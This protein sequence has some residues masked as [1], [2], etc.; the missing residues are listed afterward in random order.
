MCVRVCVHVC[1]RV[2]ACVCVLSASTKYSQSFVAQNIIWIL[3]QGVVTY[4]SPV[5]AFATAIKN[6]DLWKLSLPLTAWLLRSKALDRLIL[7]EF[8]G[9]N[10]ATPAKY[11]RK[12]V[13]RLILV[14][15]NSSWSLDR[16]LKRTLITWFHF[17]PGRKRF[18]WRRLC[19]YPL[20]LSSFTISL[21]P[22]LPIWRRA[23]LISIANLCFPLKVRIAAWSVQNR[24]WHG[25]TPLACHLHH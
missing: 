9:Q 17:D 14:A 20:W 2:C 24:A 19:D 22:A 4:T 3:V 10:V 7:R 16:L 12:C 1:V 15:Q 11:L 6:L 5:D 8:K 13:D 18:Y 25:P 21:S 23:C